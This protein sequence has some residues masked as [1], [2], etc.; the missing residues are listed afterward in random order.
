MSTTA[1]RRAG[2]SKSATSRADAVEPPLRAS[3]QRTRDTILA[4]ATA[5]FAERGFDGARIDEIAQRAG[6]PKNLLYYHFGD[7]DGLFTAVLELMYETIRAR[8]NDLHIRD[9]DPVEGMRQL[10][11]F[12]GRIW[13]QHPE[14]MRLVHSENIHNARHIRASKR[15]AS[16]YSPLMDTLRDLVERGQ[17]AGLFRPG[18]DLVELYISISSLSAHYISNHRTIDTVLRA[19]AMTPA[20]VKRRLEHAVEMVLTWLAVPAKAGKR[21]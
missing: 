5:S 4:A 3:T 16:M 7:K 19:R 13:V 15:I 8:Q 17:E 1:K 12:T 11:L 6:V 20:R 18:I 10:V 14:F 9:L 2:S 21:R